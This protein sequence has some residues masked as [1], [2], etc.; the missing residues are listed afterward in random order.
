LRNTGNTKAFI[1]VYKILLDTISETLEYHESFFI[2]LLEENKV[3][4]KQEVWL[5][6]ELKVAQRAFYNL[7][8]TKSFV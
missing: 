1:D 6:K 7:H 8:R 2:N 4:W 5:L 3:N